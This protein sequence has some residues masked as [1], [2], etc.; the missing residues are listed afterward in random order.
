MEDAIHFREMQLDCKKLW[1]LLSGA[2]Q[3]WY[4]DREN[5]YARLFAHAGGWAAVLE[6]GGNVAV[7]R[8][9]C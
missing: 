2:A 9:S 3:D 6:I 5:Y 7:K 4:A 1:P 8:L